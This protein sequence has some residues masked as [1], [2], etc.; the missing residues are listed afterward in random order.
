MAD[1]DVYESD[2]EDAAKKRCNWCNM[3]IKLLPNK[4]YCAK[5]SRGCFRECRRCHRPLPNERYFEKDENRC[6]SC[7]EKYQKEKKKRED[8]KRKE[9]EKRNENSDVSDNSETIEDAAT[10]TTTKQTQKRPQ[11]KDLNRKNRIIIPS[12]K[13]RYIVIYEADEI[14]E[15]NE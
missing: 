6:N 10:P 1:S 3:L 14:E 12:K 4:P 9:L 11:T 5:C 15:K 7:H 2:I 13:M 8:K